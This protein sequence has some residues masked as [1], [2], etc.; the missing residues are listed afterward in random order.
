MFALPNS[1]GNDPK[2][3]ERFFDSIFTAIV[4]VIIVLLDFI[5]VIFLL[6]D[7]VFARRILQSIE[8]LVCSVCV[9]FLCRTRQDNAIR[10]R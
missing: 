10:A 5:F 9:I 4:Y 6:F 3:F 8:Q 1:V 2:R 7:T